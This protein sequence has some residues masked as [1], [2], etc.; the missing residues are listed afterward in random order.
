MA[1]YPE[2]LAK[3]L[4]QLRLLPD[5]S[6]RIQW[7]VDV[8]DRFRSVPERIAVRP[9]P[10]SHQTP[11]CESE[12]YVWAEPQPDGTLRFW[13]AVENPQGVSAKSLAVILDETLS[14]TPPEQ[15]AAMP[16][17][18]VDEIFGRELSMGKNM[19]LRGMIAMVQNSAR[20]FLAKG[21]KSS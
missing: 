14:G 2:R 8:S 18:F 7:L 15:I 1:E 19:G 17:D 4:G 16:S 13:F 5:R 6:E 21:L 10:T 11:A 3:L 20:S 9:F 12:A